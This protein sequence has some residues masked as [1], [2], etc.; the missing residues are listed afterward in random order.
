ME[1]DYAFLEVSN[2]G[3]KP[4]VPDVPT[5]VPPPTSMD[6][7]NRYLAYLMLPDKEEWEVYT[8]GERMA[9]MIEIDKIEG[10]RVT[11]HE[12]NQLEKVTQTLKE[13]GD[14]NR[15]II[16]IGKAEDLIIKH[17]PCMR[18]I[19]MKVRYGALHMSLY[20]RSWDAWG[21]LPSNLAALQL[22]KESIASDLGVQDG[23]IFAASMGLHVYENEWEYARA[24]TGV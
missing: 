22:M 10:T 2:P 13:T 7:V 15:G 4:L 16:A 20:F 12:F 14:T 8:Y 1:L 19:Q 9:S 24:V 17:P 3:N 21:G 5:D 6:Y 23:K 18:L 11:S